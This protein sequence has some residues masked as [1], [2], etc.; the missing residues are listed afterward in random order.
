MIKVCRGNTPWGVNGHLHRWTAGATKGLR[1]CIEHQRK[2]LGGGIPVSRAGLSGNTTEQGGGGPLGGGGLLGASLLL[3]QQ[4]LN[5]G[6]WGQREVQ[7]L[8]R[9]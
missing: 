7:T 6:L 4:R 5:G 2:Q 1:V 3:G 8:K 9:G